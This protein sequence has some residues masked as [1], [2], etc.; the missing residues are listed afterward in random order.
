[1]Y[2]GPGYILYGLYK[3]FF[4]FGNLMYIAFNICCWTLAELFLVLP[5]N[6]YFVELGSNFDSLIHLK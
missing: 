6:T 4:Q 2:T 3:L 1:M 5:H